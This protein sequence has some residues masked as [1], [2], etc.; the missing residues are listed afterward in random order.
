LVFNRRRGQQRW[1]G[2]DDLCA[3]APTRSKFGFGGLTFSDNNALKAT[4][5]TVYSFQPG[6]SIRTWLQ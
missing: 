3:I 2:G 1:A 4:N 5:T 6:F